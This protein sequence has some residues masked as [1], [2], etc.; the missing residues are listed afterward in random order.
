MVEFQDDSKYRVDTL[1]ANFKK[2]TVLNP[3]DRNVGGVGYLGEGS[4][5][6][7]INNK[8]TKE[9]LAWSAMIRRCYMKGSKKYC[10]AYYNKATVCDE[11]QCYQTF[12]EWYCSNYY[13]VDNE[14]T[15]LDK[16]ILCP[17]NMVYTPNKC[18]IV[19]QRINMLFMTK[20]KSNGLPTGISQADQRYYAIYNG[21]HLGAYDTAEDAFAMYA[22]AKEAAIKNV[23][24]QYQNRIPR[25]V[26]EALMQYRVLLE[27]DK[28]YCPNTKEKSNEV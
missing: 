15:H 5:V 8:H 28:N 1:Y 19:P 17:G 14:R 13:V 20:H 16:D 3:Y 2:G 7:M 9:Y 21:K 26:Y 4:H 22:T 27:N 10:K 18:L 24:K 6:S 12:A 23:A 11:W 25:P